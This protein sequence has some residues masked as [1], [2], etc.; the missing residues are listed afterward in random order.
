MSCVLVYKQ[1]FIVQSILYIHAHV[2]QSLVLPVII[3]NST[4]LANVNLH[5]YINLKLHHMSYLQ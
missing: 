3:Q 4:G 5:V 2:Q 1:D